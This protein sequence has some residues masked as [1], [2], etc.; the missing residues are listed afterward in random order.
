MTLRNHRDD[1][2]I[3]NAQWTRIREEIYN[4]L[5]T[6]FQVKAIPR[7]GRLTGPDFMILAGLTSFADWIGSNREFFPFGSPEDCKDVQTLWNS[8]R[9]MANVALSQIGWERREPLIPDARTFKEMFAREPRPL[10]TATAAMLAG[11]NEPAVVLI[12]APMG[13]GKTEAAFLAH[14]D[15]QRTLGHRGLYMALPSQATGNAMFER[16][17]AFLKDNGSCRSLDL[18]LLH[19]A[20]L[21][22]DSYQELR[23]EGVDDGDEK[24]SVRAREWFTHKKRALLSE[25]GV[26]TVDQGLL[27]IL[28]IRH[29]FVRLWGLANRTVVFDE[30]HAYDAYTGA[31]LITLITWLRALGSSVILLS[32]TL[33][34][35]FRRKLASRLNVALPDVEAAYPRITRFTSDKVVQ[36]HF[37]ADPARR[38][39]ITVQGI[40]TSVTDLKGRLLSELSN[41]GYGLAL[42]NTVQR[43]QE[44]YRAFGAGETIELDG[45][46]VGKRLQDGTEVLLFHARFPASLRR[47]REAHS[48]ENFGPTASRSGRKILIATQVAEQSLDLDFDVMITDLAPIDLVLQRAGRLWRHAR[49]ARPVSEAKL[50]VAGLEGERPPSF[51]KPLWWG[52]VYEEECLLRTWLVLQQRKFLTVPDDID[53]LVR[54]VYDEKSTAV[55]EW[56]EER[57]AGAEVEAATRRTC[58]EIFA[59]QEIIGLPDDQSWNDPDK[60]AKFDQEETTAHHTLVAKTR[61]GDPSVTAVLVPPSEARWLKEPPP[62]PVAKGLYG[63]VLSISRQ[64]IV[65]VLQAPG[66]Y[67]AWSESPLLRNCFPIE[68]DEN[69]CWVRDASVRLDRELGLIFEEKERK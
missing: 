58:H 39:T 18:Q 34:P 40:G 3:G 33:P 61:L 62:F 24:G 16:T 8:R 47:Q 1:E 15:L 66:S 51:A 23:L 68:L 30:I 5:E 57:L 2:A 9:G 6:L 13:E 26:G 31:L 65:R 4:S 69:G 63:N 27:T 60:M 19:G 41:G 25:Y 43:A 52:K 42:V 55:P 35:S 45:T 53:P 29:Q 22:N 21:L 36:S 49:D 17:L 14:A 46:V 28:P 64:G 38:R 50:F 56:L 54:E 10:Q 48:L 44:V 20:T 32:A 37:A 59:N 12:E 11:C 7:S 67:A